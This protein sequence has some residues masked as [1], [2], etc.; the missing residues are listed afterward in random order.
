MGLGRLRLSLLAVAAASA[1]IA[2][3]EPRWTIYR[4]KKAELAFC[5][6]V[7]PTGA[8]AQLNGQQSFFYTCDSPEGRFVAGYTPIPPTFQQTMKRGIAA[9]PGSS[10]IMHLLDSTVAAFAKGGNAKVSGMS[11]GMDH[12]L[13]AEFA[14]LKNDHTTLKMRVYLC[15]KRLYIFVASTDRDSA[16]RFFSSIQIPGE[17][18][19][20]RG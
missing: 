15:S 5:M 7:K 3:Q 14:T 17:I 6:P 9:D 4:I 19:K 20:W 1:A 11:F 16:S 18:K 13:P 8:P 2:Y 10:G 12:E